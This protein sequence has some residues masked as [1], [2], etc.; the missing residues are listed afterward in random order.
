MKVIT[1]DGKIIE[2]SVAAIEGGLLCLEDF[3]FIELNEVLR[4]E[5]NAK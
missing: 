2:C 3:Y 4:I 5:E 1:K